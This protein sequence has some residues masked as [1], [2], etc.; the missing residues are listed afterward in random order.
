MNPLRPLALRAVPDAVTA[1]ACERCDDTGWEL[2]DGG[3][4][5]C[6]C[7]AE[8]DRSAAHRRLLAEIPTLYRGCSRAT[9]RGRWPAAAPVAGARWWDERWLVF[10]HGGVTGCGKT[11][12]A[13]AVFLEAVESGEFRTHRW[14]STKGLL[15]AVT[16]EIAGKAERRAERD[17]RE[18][19]L[20]LLDDLGAERATDFAREVLA[21]ILCHRYDWQLPTILTSNADDLAAIDALDPRLSSRL[22]HRSLL[23]H[24]GGEDARI[25]GATE[26]RR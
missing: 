12:L 5:R 26:D 6:A 16:D 19:Q 1:A 9:W 14:L 13:T 8:A 7:M 20:L 10:V 24:R 21:G 4:R 2:V 18:A 25:P 11:H 15:S 3:A 23:V 17:A 22:A